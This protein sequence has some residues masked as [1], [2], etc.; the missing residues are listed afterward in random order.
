MVR[1]LIWLSDFLVIVPG[2]VGVVNMLHTGI[3]Q[4]L[5]A[6]RA[7][8][9]VCKLAIDKL[10]I[11][12]NFRPCQVMPAGSYQSINLGM[13]VGDW[14]KVSTVDIATM[15]ERMSLEAVPAFA[16]NKVALNDY[17]SN[18]NFGSPDSGELGKLGIGLCEIEVSL[19]AVGGSHGSH[20]EYCSSCNMYGTLTDFSYRG[21]L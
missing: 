17:R 14:R 15:L 7:W 19:L 6:G 9:T 4:S 16:D 13:N 2:F 20:V 5:H 10:T 8:T 12:E 1:M 21:L 18:L 11:H 3:F